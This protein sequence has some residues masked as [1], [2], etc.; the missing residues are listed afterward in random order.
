MITNKFSTEILF[1]NFD[2]LRK[3]KGLN[4]GDFNK[5]IR[6]GNVYRPNYFS[7][8][9]KLLK[10]ITDN[11]PGITEEWLLTSHDANYEFPELQKLKVAESQTDYG[12]FGKLRRISD[13]PETKISELLQKTAYVLESNTLHTVAFI[14]II[15]ACHHAVKGDE[16]L[17]QQ[18]EK[19]ESLEDEIK[20]LQETKTPAANE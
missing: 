2:I 18:D 6:M 4:K 1:N 11:F 17:K 5:L 14:S 7:I 19:I 10:G 3:S 12:N 15:E 13:A 9:A 8:G 16:L 20:L